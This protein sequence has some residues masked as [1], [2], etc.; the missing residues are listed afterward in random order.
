ME[1]DIPLTKALCF[2]MYVK[3]KFNIDLLASEGKCSLPYR[4][5]CIILI[6]EVL[7]YS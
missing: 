7:E 3:V 1:T 6:C 4:R 2:E 5:S